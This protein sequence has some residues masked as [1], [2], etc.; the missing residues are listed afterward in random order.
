MTYT[1]VR[2]ENVVD[3]QQT[4]TEKIVLDFN[5]RHAPDTANSQSQ[6]IVIRN[7]YRSWIG[8]WPFARDTYCCRPVPSGRWS[9]KSAHIRVCTHYQGNDIF[10]Y[11]FV[12]ENLAK[13]KTNLEHD[14]IE[15][16]GFVLAERYFQQH[17]IPYC[18]AVGHGHWRGITTENQHTVIVFAIVQSQLTLVGE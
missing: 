9:R 2:A 16:A 1:V 7:I 17:I 8:N 14:K 13:T 11:P 12:A 3:W 10:S 18:T 15:A 6:I 4:W 5:I